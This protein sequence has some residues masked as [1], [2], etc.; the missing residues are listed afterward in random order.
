MNKHDGLADWMSKLPAELTTV[1][2]WNLA[3]PG[4]HDSMA[5]CLDTSG[6]LEPDIPSWYPNLEEVFPGVY[7][8]IIKRWTSTQALSITQ[9]LDVGVRFF[10]MRIARLPDEDDG[11]LYFAHILYTT[12]TVL[13]TFRQ[14][15]KWL[16][17]HPKEVVIISCSNFNSMSDDDHQAFITQLM[18]IFSHTLYAF[19]QNDLQGGN[20]NNLPM[21]PTDATWWTFRTPAFYVDYTTDP[22]PNVHCIALY[23]SVL[24]WLQVTPTLQDC[25]E[26]NHQVILSYADQKQAANQE[27]LWPEIDYWKANPKAGDEEVGYGSVAEKRAEEVVEYLTNRLQKEG[28]DEAKFF[29]SGLNVTA[30]EYD[31]LGDPL[32]ELVK[33]ASDAR[34]QLMQWAIKQ[35]PGPGHNCINILAMD[36]VDQEFVQT[37]IN[38]NTGK[39][40][41]TGKNDCE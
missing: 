28:R 25:W 3:I 6:D 2:L 31:V 26:K 17:E 19:D 10:D 35:Q 12:A 23:Y 22:N 16:A 14:M 5:Y 20:S 7:K 18:E 36:F 4:S 27:L 37:V 33:W 32:G 30:V 13:R 40:N 21:P 1:P 34:P 29:V 15:S 8:Y 38:I 39:E 24:F 11:T 9:Q 41:N